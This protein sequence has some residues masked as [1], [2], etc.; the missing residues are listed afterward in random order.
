MLKRIINYLIS[1]TNGFWQKFKFFLL[2]RQVQA[3]K[4]F[5][6][7]GGLKIKGPGRVIFGDNVFIDGRGRTV[8]PYTYSKDA[9]IEIGNDVFINGTRFGCQDKI[10]IGSRGILADARILDTDF[11][12]VEAN[13]H[14]SDAKVLHGPITIEENVW[15]AGGAVILKNTRIGKNSVVGFNAVVVDDVPDNCVAAGNPSKIVKELKQTDAPE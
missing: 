13:R 4:N 7:R 9:V 10:Q 11:H 15:I 2:N 1:R 6:V 3:G 14:D 12:S 5:K 8:T